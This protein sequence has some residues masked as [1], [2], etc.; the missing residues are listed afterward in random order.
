MWK[1]DTRETTMHTND[2]CETTMHTSD[3]CETT[4]HTND[5]R[6]NDTCADGSILFIGIKYDGS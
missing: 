4:M 1:N 5:T 2:T 3:T 6:L